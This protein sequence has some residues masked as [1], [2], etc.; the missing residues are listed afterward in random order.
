LCIQA[1]VPA[2]FANRHP[3]GVHDPV[4]AARVVVKLHNN[5]KNNNNN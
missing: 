2:Q 1:G 3:P 4:R 5:N